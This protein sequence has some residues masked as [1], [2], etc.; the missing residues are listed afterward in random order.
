MNINRTHLAVTL[1]L[2]LLLGCSGSVEDYT[3]AERVTYLRSFDSEGRIVSESETT[4]FERKVA[5]RFIEDDPV[6]KN[7]EYRYSG[8]TT[9][10][11]TALGFMLGRKIE[12]TTPL[13]KETIEMDGADTLEY[14]KIG[15]LD[16]TRTK[17]R[18]E[19]IWSSVQGYRYS[20]EYLY[21]GDT[22]Y[23]IKTVDIATGESR[24]IRH[25]YGVDPASLED[26]LDDTI[27]I[28]V[29][30]YQVADTTFTINLGDDQDGNIMKQYYRGDREFTEAWNSDGSLHYRR[31]N[32]TDSNGYEVQLFD[33]PLMGIQAT[34]YS[35]NGKLVRD[36]STI[37]DGTTEEII[38]EYDSKG[39]LLKKTTYIR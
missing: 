10:K 28:V 32:Y 12:I 18:R 27:D 17:Y 14:Y 29:A 1:L 8:D 4:I 20:S 26:Y 13:S 9:I 30:E 31:E 37:F 24:R 33:M 21:C 36:I 19:D 23:T 34:A 22:L 7:S 5:D 25:L 39:N 35:L 38:Y 2:T 3:M 11:V 15:Y 16:S 6:V